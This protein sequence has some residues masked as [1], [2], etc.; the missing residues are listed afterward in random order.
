[1]QARAGK[2]LV[3][4]SIMTLRSFLGSIGYYSRFI[5][6]FSQYSLILTPAA[7]VKAPGTD[8]LTPKMLDA[9]HTLC[10]SLYDFCVLTIP[11]VLDSFELHTDA[12]GQG[13][14]SVLNVVRRDQVL[15]VAFHSRQEE[16]SDIILLQNWR[17]W[18]CAKPSSVSR[19]SYMVHR[20]G[21]SQTT[22]L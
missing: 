1:M 12:S 21:Y 2:P 10:E 20:S 16:V 17:C 11:S 4:S 9:S 3:W 6:R 19:T 14:G 15:P 22:N 5:P 8:C 7:L 18:L 13:I